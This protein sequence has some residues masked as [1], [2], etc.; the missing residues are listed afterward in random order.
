MLRRAAAALTVVLAAGC[1]GGAGGMSSTSAVGPSQQVTVKAAGHPFAAADAV[2]EAG[3]TSSAQSQWS[4]PRLHVE[5]PQVVGATAFNVAATRLV[6]AQVADYR[7]AAGPV[8]GVATPELTMT[9]SALA[10]GDG[11]V[12]VR[13]AADE[14]LGA[15]NG[16]VSRTLYGTRDGASAWAGADLVRP[17]QRGRL[18]DLVVAAADRDHMRRADDTLPEPSDLL[19]DVEV[20]RD[21]GLRL[22]V[23]KG[24]VAGADLG[25]MT[26][27]VGPA[28]ARA[29]LSDA[30]RRVATAVAASRPATPMPSTAPTQTPAQTP[31]VDC[32]RARCIA[33]TFDDGPG[34]HTSRILDTLAAHDARASFFMIGRSVE[35]MPDVVKRAHDLGMAIGD[36]TWT[37]RDLARTAP[38][39]VESEIARTAS[40]IWTATGARPFAVRPPYGSFSAS[41]PRL[42]LPFVL[43]DVDTEDWRNRDPRET[44]RRALAGARPGAIVLMH[45]IHASTAEALDGIITGLQGRGYAL[46]TVPEL[47]GGLDPAKAYYGAHEPA[48]D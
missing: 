37:H 18:V 48:R 26:V 39:D 24:V 9:W 40:A 8:A 31:R 43:W 1:S 7:E 38:G 41:T 22:L 36:H 10:D 14:F 12:G 16:T 19:D 35:G 2:A 33:L 20:T 28:T 15:S 6:D 3:I 17:D 30:G 13:V 45:D 47:L 5:R 32:A 46:V 42:G 34:P 25:T 21:G 11:V 27:T 23:G 29:L 4:H 44:T